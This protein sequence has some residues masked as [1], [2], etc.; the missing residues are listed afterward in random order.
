MRAP[1]RNAAAVTPL[2]RAVL[3][4]DLI[5]LT[6]PVYGLDV[7]GQMKAFIDHLCFMWISHRPNPQMFST[8]G[9]TVVTTAGAG[10]KHAT[11]NVEELL[12]LLGR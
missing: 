11:K 12:D 8:I 4:A 2:V 3:D 9:L 5:V 10:L 6:S 7:T 1:V